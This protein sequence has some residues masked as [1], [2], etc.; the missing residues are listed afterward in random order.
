V[1]S[2]IAVAIDRLR[3]SMILRSLNT[4][5]NMVHK[6]KLSCLV[7]TT[8]TMYVITVNMKN[9]SMPDNYLR[10]EI[11]RCLSSLP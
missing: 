4:F 11:R 10:Y 7:L 5:K 6:R 9:R 2:S 1:Q 8:D 3:G